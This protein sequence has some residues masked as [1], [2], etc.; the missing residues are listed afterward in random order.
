MVEGFFKVEVRG[1]P[2]SRDQAIAFRNR[3]FIVV[4]LIDREAILE[5]TL[6]GEIAAIYTWTGI[7]KDFGSSQLLLKFLKT[8]VGDYFKA[9]KLNFEMNFIETEELHGA[10]S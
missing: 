4:K 2:K 7:P 3:C 6:F 8:M 1:I 5:E 9:W 10:S